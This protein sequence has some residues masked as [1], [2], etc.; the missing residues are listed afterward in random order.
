MASAAVAVSVPLGEY[1]DDKLLNLG[2]NRVVIRPQIG[3]LHTRGKWSYEL[4][5]SAF[6]YGDNDDF[7]GGST[8]EQDPLY[9]LQAHLI[10]TFN[11]GSD[12]DSLAVGWSYRF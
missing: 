11:K 5:G 12:T 3:I 6:L 8:L 1:F 4:T 2:H 9:A 7:Y 10:R